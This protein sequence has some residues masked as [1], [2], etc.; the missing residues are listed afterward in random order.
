MDFS[1]EPIRQIREN[2]LNPCPI[3]VYSHTSVSFNP[4]KIRH[5]QENTKK[6]VKSVFNSHT[7]ASCVCREPRKT[8][9]KDRLALKQSSLFLVS[10]N[11]HLS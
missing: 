2:P 9:E 1:H 5:A 11:L 3:A 8:K 7:P 6:S 4:K 10:Q